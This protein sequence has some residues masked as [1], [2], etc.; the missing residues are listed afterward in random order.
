LFAA[1][2]GQ[3]IGVLRECDNSNAPSGFPPAR[4]RHR[5]DIGGEF[6]APAQPAGSAGFCPEIGRGLRL[7]TEIILQHMALSAFDR[8]HPPSYLWSACF[9]V[10][11]LKTL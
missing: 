7:R 1:K 9:G 3:I 2:I 10:A 5:G 6:F 4:V 11:L 8:S